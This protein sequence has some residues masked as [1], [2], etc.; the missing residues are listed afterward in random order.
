MK[1]NQKN[2]NEIRIFSF[3][4]ITQTSKKMK[5]IYQVEATLTYNYKIVVDQDQDENKI[6]MANIMFVKNDIDPEEA[7]F[8]KEI[9]I[10]PNLEGYEE[11]YNYHGNVNDFVEEYYQ[12]PEES[13]L[14]N[15]TIKPAIGQLELF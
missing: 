15:K 10:H 12:Q 7:F 1:E 2:N 5:K 8:I 13:D 6:A 4:N 14:E 9:E 11:L 3:T